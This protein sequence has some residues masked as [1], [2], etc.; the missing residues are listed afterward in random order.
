V[1]EDEN[2]VINQFEKEKDA[3]INEELGN[4]IKIPDIK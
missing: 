4:Q 3:E 2:Q 1:T